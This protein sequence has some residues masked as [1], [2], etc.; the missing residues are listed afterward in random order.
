[1][2]P[3]QL[4]LSAFGAY[5]GVE[6]VDFEKFSGIFL[7]SGDTGAGKTTIFD[8]ISFAL[9]G[10]TSGGVREPKSLR[11]DYASPSQKT[12]AKLVFEHGG[13]NY[14]LLRNPEYTRSALRG[15]GL[16]NENA[17]AELIMPDGSAVTGTTKVND[18]IKEIT[19]IKDSDTFRQI[20]MIAQNDFAK[21]LTAKSE[22]RRQLYSSI[23]GTGKYG[24]FC[25]ELKNRSNAALGD[26]KLAKDMLEAYAERF[27]GVEIKKEDTWTSPKQV[28]ERVEARI[29][30]KHGEYDEIKVE[31][32]RLDEIR[33]QADIEYD[34][35]V[36]LN[37]KF[38]RLEEESSELEAEKEKDGFF[39][40]ESER[41]MLSE[42]AHRCAEYGR[43]QTAREAHG[44]AENELSKKEEKRAAAEKLKNEKAEALK[45]I[46]KKAE[47]LPD[48][49]GLISSAKKAA[50]DF[51]AAEKL[52]ES[53]KK[54]EYEKNA[55]LF[56][57]ERKNA[58]KE[59]SEA[60]DERNA[61]RQ[62]YKDTEGITAEEAAIKTLR[63]KLEEKYA[64]FTAAD[65]KYREAYALFISGQAGILAKELVDGVPCPV[66][67]S[68]SHPAPAKFTEEMPD[69]ALV[70]KLEEERKLI[71]EETEKLSAK[72]GA[73]AAALKEKKNALAEK[74]AAHGLK[75]GFT[76]ED[77]TAIGKP[78]GENIRRFEEKLLIIKAELEKL[79]EEAVREAKQAVDE[80]DETA[81]LFRTEK[82]KNLAELTARR[83]L[84]SGSAEFKDRKDAENKLKN[85]ER[86]KNEIEEEL[87]K[88][89]EES[90]TQNEKFSA[91]EAELG[92]AKNAFKEAKE[93]LENADIAFKNAIAQLGFSG[94]EEYLASR[95][96][97]E[98][99]KRIKGG[100]DNHNTV[101]AQMEG[102]ISSLE[103]EL[104]GAE[105]K[106]VSE[107]ALRINKLAEESEGV[108]EKQKVI[109]AEIGRNE[110]ELPRYKKD[111]EGYAERTKRAE[112][113]NT[114][115]SVINGR[116]GGIKLNFET[117]VQTVYFEK[118]VAQ[119]NE[120][121]RIMSE[122]RYFLVRRE[123]A[124]G[125]SQTGLDLNVFDSQTGKERNVSSLSGG[126]TFMA[127][128]SLA[129]GLSDVIQQMNGGIRADTLFI[130]EGFGTLD[131]NAREQ[132]IRALLR[133]SE[134]NK[135]V[136]LISHVE[137]L[138]ERIGQQITVKKGTNGS[139]ITV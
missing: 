77:V 9:F 104:S 132:A 76:K 13:L 51:S 26:L 63:G 71:K 86:E 84:L 88:A 96:S 46:E 40:K 139:R 24:R 94:E 38:T 99:E 135:L 91:A 23:F 126:E 17:Y 90:K 12:Y 80:S 75:D 89:K 108:R 11:S 8:G 69:K 113:L 93:E 15:G 62:I 52:E 92:M 60:E 122:G 5:P 35:A 78:I 68:L 134:G 67:G 133:V 79:P 116:A 112:L 128:L 58:E 102:S 37:E 106:D 72:I 56:V 131:E 39:E 21:L 53:I 18:K 4:E 31:L 70:D 83:D 59:K 29:N 114:M 64:G 36:K 82:E 30:E 73:D 1:M 111:A 130:D 44:K 103:K 115:N 124:G 42:K 43:K 66:C 97:E 19:G 125:N 47:K 85:A 41:L 14:T 123:N 87:K 25:T 20:S 81:E 138:K 120:R 55:V 110:T 22:E 6:K 33:K 3:L 57:M 101:K 137:D 105:R 107:I 118:V 129:L 50:E 65:E 16:T 48:L 74:G 117:Y 7:I 54:A 10:Q 61:L 49:T 119:A 121:L 95:L 2:R 28:M 27:S 127:S 45:A 32:E 34:N 136:G 109:F 98:E 100:V